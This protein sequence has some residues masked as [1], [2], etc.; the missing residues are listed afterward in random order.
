MPL[1]PSC[2]RENPDGFRHCGYCGAPLAS[3]AEQRRK[4]ATLLFCDLSGSTAMGERIDAE[5]VRSLMLSYFD[6]MRSTLQGHGGTVEKFVGDAVLAVFGVPDAHEDDALRACRAALEMRERLASLNDRFEERYGTRIA[7]RIGVNS[8]EVVAGDPATRETFV[9]GDPVNVAARL[10]QHASE[11]EILLGEA[12]LRLVRE[13]VEVEAVEPLWAKGKSD[14]LPAYR[15]LSAGVPDAS[16]PRHATLFVGRDEQVDLLQREFQHAVAAGRCRL[17]TVIGEP[18]VGK[19]RLAAEL[20]SRLTGQAEI[21][22]G[23]CL[24]YG[25]GITYW[26]IAG[27]VRALLG[28][29]EGRS[30][31]QTIAAVEERLAGRPEGEAV[32]AKIGLLLGAVDGTATAAEIA[33]AIRHFLAAEAG[34]RPLVIVVEDIHWAEEVLLRLLTELAATV[35][36]PVLIVCLARTDL[37]D[38]RPEWRVDVRLDPLGER[39][40]QTLLEGLVGELPPPARERLTVA[41]AGNPLFL[42]ELVGVLVEDGVLGRGAGGDGVS[43]GD[44]D[45]VTLPPTLHALLAARLDRL[46]PAGR[47]T[48]ERGSI[49][50]EIFHRDAI[51]DL[52]PSDLRDA[53]PRALEALT[54]GDLVRPAPPTLAATGAF[55]FKHILLRDAAYAGIAKLTRA[56]LHERFAGWLERL[57]GEE[58]R[59]YEEILGYHLE[60]SYQYRRSLGRLDDAARALGDRAADWLDSAGRQAQTRGDST[61][62]ARLFAAAQ[63]LASGAERQAELALRQGIAAREA[64]SLTAAREILAGVLER[65]RGDGWARLEAAADVELGVL[66]VFTSTGRTED[67]RA[68]GERALA[69]F[70]ALGDDGGRASALALLAWERWRLLR[71]AEAERLFERALPPAQR[72]GEGR[73]VAMLLLGL[74]R[75]AVFGPRPVRDALERCTSLL[76]QAHSIGPMVAANIAML[77]TLPEAQLGN[78]DTARRLGEEAKAAMQEFETNAWIGFMPY[79]AM[80]ALLAGDP[81]HAER[82]LRGV[83]ENLGEVGEQAF[84]STV[85]AL[86][87]RAQVELGRFAEAERESQRA[88]DLAEPDDAATQAYAR[89]ARA[90][91]LAAGGRFDEALS[92]ATMAVSAVSAADVPDI[93]GDVCFDLAL[94]QHVSGAPAEAAETARRAL[95]LFCAKGN[96]ASVARVEA[97]LG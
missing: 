82:E 35:A 85:S 73:L 43:A 25:E 69:T 26:P 44:L 2:G 12:T 53:V 91:S 48:L 54:S 14:P 94:V 46:D 5:A 47:A 8:G 28:E 56:E 4:L 33:W 97:F 31:A 32:A 75:A 93:L 45:Q 95:E 18:G 88:L 42:E 64:I 52:S 38:S 51:L 49:E 37:L 21:V 55:R 62:A 76:E 65:A 17:V 61:A 59:G 19:S 41:S 20:A 7:L 23:R 89:A 9:T 80:V 92:E 74:A 29:A 67:L 50:G 1:C 72:A 16:G 71:C 30:R 22:G 79:V 87:A 6:E 83:A 70:E 68:A 90:R 24:S 78:F 11:N 27:V 86:R 39:D 84:A 15:L 58:T 66:S 3:A 10:E 57:L 81:A 63:E 40:V 77:R 36:A 96:V 13:A 34:R 60:Q